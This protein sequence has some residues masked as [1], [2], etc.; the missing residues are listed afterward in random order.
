M[1]NTKKSLLLFAAF[2]LLLG[3]QACTKKE[4]KEAPAEGGSA[5][6]PAGEGQIGVA[7]CDEYL[8]KV[9]KCIAD[10]VPDA[11][12]AMMKDSIGKN[13]DAWKQAASTPE[14]KAALSM[15]CKQAL[16]AAK[17]SMGAYGCEF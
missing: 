1:K 13:I 8:S 4:S 2:A 5:A 12:K 3:S 9:Q 14:G 11:A 6:A 10:K 15:G 17:S 16:D 7:E